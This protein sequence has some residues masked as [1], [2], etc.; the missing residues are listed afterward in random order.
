MLLRTLPQKLDWVLNKP[1]ILSSNV[2]WH[3]YRLITETKVFRLDVSLIYVLYVKEDWISKKVY[4]RKIYHITSNTENFQAYLP[5]MIKFL[6]VQYKLTLNLHLLY[7][8]Y[9][10]IWIYTIIQ[11]YI[12]IY[13]YIYIIY[14]LYIYIYIYITLV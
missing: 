12:Y 13:I 3:A 5:Q 9:N 11:L 1:L 8:I 4:Y 7:R 14:I 10:F 6:I 2:I